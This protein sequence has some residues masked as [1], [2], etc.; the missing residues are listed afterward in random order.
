MEL[1]IFTL[2]QDSNPL[3][4]YQIQSKGELKTWITASSTLRSWEKWVILFCNK[5]RLKVMGFAE[6]AS[7]PTPSHYSQQSEEQKTSHKLKRGKFGNKKKKKKE[8]SASWQAP[9]NFEDWLQGRQ[10]LNRSK[11]FRMEYRSKWM[12]SLRKIKKKWCF[13]TLQFTI[14]SIIFQLLLMMCPPL[15]SLY[16]H[17][18]VC[19][20]IL[21]WECCRLWTEFHLAKW[22]M[23][24]VLINA[25]HPIFQEKKSGFF[26]PIWLSYVCF[27]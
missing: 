16:L 12:L 1:Y 17:H 8:K 13:H 27:S 23:S 24:G 3:T 10:G 14:P 6:H 26:P 7:N 15:D 18:E 5:C 22:Q 9:L 4:E 20:M 21:F 25:F 2:K 11:P 19:Y